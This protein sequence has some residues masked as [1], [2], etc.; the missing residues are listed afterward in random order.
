[1]LDP[2]VATRGLSQEGRFEMT[3]STPT[4]AQALGIGVEKAIRGL[5]SGQPVL[6][7]D[8]RSPGAWDSGCTKIQGAIRIP[9]D[10]FEIDPSWPKDRFTLA[11]GTCPKDDETSLGVAQELRRERFTQAYALQGG[12]ESWLQ[13]AGPIE[14]RD[15]SQ[16]DPR[17]LPE[18]C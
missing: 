10:Q 4:Q 5:E 7:L 16:S 13:A 6:V 3:V 8:V 14:P 11:Y 9:P 17:I 15:A 1:M 2:R 12:Y 18:T